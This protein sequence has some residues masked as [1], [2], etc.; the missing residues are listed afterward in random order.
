V[1]TSVGGVRGRQEGP[2]LR[3]S[4]ATQP[5]AGSTAC[6]EPGG[7]GVQLTLLLRVPPDRLGP[8]PHNNNTRQARAPLRH[9][10]L[11]VVGLL[12]R[13]DAVGG[14]RAERQ[15]LQAAAVV[16]HTDVGGAGGGAP[17]EQRAQH[18]H[19]HAVQH[20]LAAQ[21][22]SQGMEGGKRRRRAARWRAA[23]AGGQRQQRWSARR[24]TAVALMRSTVIR[25]SWYRSIIPAKRGRAQNDVESPGAGQSGSSAQ[26]L[27]ACRS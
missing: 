22:R 18:S 26:V 17:S 19:V 24:D 5:R 4:S 21:G 14:G 15:R 13:A 3:L 16:L 6:K 7:R 27:T 23:A 9:V 20:D 25:A 1:H 8:P 11:R 10:V 12:S 2:G